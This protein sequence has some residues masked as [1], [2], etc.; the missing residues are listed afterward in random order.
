MKILIVGDGTSFACRALDVMVKEGLQIKV[1]QE[2]SL[3]EAEDFNGIGF[4]PVADS[5]RG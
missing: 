1:N 5:M 4:E 3:Y 2:E